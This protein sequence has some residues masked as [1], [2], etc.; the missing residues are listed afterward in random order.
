MPALAAPKPASNARK[1]PKATTPFQAL[2][3]LVGRTLVILML[4]ATVTAGATAIGSSPFAAALPST[5]LPFAQQGH[6]GPS[7][8]VANASTSGQAGIGRGQQPVASGAQPTAPQG[9]VSGRN[10][11]NIIAGLR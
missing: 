3:Q 6:G 11:P 7:T 5:I 2:R 10:A 8:Q 9:L 4:A 1:S